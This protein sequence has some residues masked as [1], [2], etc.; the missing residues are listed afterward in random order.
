VTAVQKLRAQA[1]LLR[2][3]DIGPQ[4]ALSLRADFVDNTQ[5]KPQE[6]HVEEAHGLIDELLAWSTALAPLRT[7]QRAAV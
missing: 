7:A 5:F 2:M 3:A 1:G 6:P 4:V